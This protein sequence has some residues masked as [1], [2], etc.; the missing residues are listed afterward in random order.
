MNISK[1]KWVNNIN[2]EYHIPMENQVKLLNA[3]A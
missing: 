3:N 1:D 2:S